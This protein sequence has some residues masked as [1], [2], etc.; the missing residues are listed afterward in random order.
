M[1]TAQKW[2]TVTSE[3][4]DAWILAL[5]QAIQTGR[6]FHAMLW[7]IIWARKPG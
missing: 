2:G 1:R 6:F 4:A 3:E 5:K 7:F